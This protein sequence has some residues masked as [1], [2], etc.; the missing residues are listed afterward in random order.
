MNE[1]QIKKAIKAIE[2]VKEETLRW[3]REKK[4]HDEIL[5]HAPYI[6][7]D[8]QGELLISAESEDSYPFADYYGEFRGGY[9]YINP[10]LEDALLK[11]GFFLEWKNPGCLAVYPN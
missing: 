1:Q 3:N 4:E 7:R 9:P 6:N 11:A 10:K 5:V 8:Y 2:S